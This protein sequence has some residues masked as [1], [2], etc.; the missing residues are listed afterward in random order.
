MKSILISEFAKAVVIITLFVLLIPYL[1]TLLDYVK[2]IFNLVPWQ[3][4]GWINVA[5]GF[6]MIKFIVRL[7]SA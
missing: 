2:V 6:I 3:F 7:L 4:S 1:S 5:F